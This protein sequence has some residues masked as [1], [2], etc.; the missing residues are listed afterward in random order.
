MSFAAS[1]L[2]RVK[3]RYNSMNSRSGSIGRTFGAGWTYIVVISNPFTNGRSQTWPIVG[4]RNEKAHR[5]TGVIRVAE[6]IGNGTSNITERSRSSSSTQELKDDEHRIVVCQRRAD[7]KDRID[8]NAPNIDPFA[9][10]NVAQRPQKRWSHGIPNDE[11]ALS[12]RKDLCRA[13]ELFLDQELD[14]HVGGR[15]QSDED[16]EETVYRYDDPFLGH[17]PVDWMSSIS[18]VDELEEGERGIVF[19]YGASATLSE[20]VIRVVL[21]LLLC[22]V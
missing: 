10:T 22:F 2:G 17:R 11:H 3:G 15:C 19:G 1:L 8:S 18:D 16:L 21:R 14:A 9:A 12:Q 5:L 20:L 4:C 6:Q 7:V 13:A